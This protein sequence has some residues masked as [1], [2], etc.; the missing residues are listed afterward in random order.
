M[1]WLY[2][3][4]QPACSESENRSYFASF[5]SETLQECGFIML[6][7]FGRAKIRNIYDIKRTSIVYYGSEFVVKVSKVDLLS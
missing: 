1:T 7:R 6:G 4:C 3:L 2:A 5:W